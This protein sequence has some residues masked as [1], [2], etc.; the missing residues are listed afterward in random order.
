MLRRC[1]GNASRSVQSVAIEVRSALLSHSQGVFPGTDIFPTVLISNRSSGGRIVTARNL[2]DFAFRFESLSTTI[3]CCSRSPN[4]NG[5]SLESWTI[6]TTKII[7]TSKLP[8]REKLPPQLEDNW[9][10]AMRWL[11]SLE[12]S[13]ARDP[14]K[15]ASYQKFADENQALGHKWEIPSQ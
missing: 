13:F 1:R 8:K 14:E 5:T 12:R 9:Y 10:N 4:S 15:Y 11:Y 2:L 3:I 7:V 6:M